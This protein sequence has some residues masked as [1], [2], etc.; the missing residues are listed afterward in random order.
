MAEA[1]HTDGERVRLG[2]RKCSGDGA[3]LAACNPKLLKA[4][5]DIYQDGCHLKLLSTVVAKLQPFI[6]EDMTNYL[7]IVKGTHVQWKRRVIQ[8]CRNMW[9][10]FTKIDSL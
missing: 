4:L 1:G 7:K 6:K 5:E 3:A 10:Q 2:K 9:N 8:N